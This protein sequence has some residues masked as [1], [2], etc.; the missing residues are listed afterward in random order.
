[1]FY[2][3]V[4]DQLTT[5]QWEVRHLIYVQVAMLSVEV[6]TPGPVAVMDSGVGQL[7]CVYRVSEC[8]DYSVV[9]C[10]PHSR[11]LL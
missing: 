2:T 9:E 11:F 6:P 5:D 3:M 10:V 4:E 8:C 1:M 7:Q